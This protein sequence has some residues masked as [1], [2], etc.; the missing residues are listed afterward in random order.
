L[1]SELGSDCHRVALS[2]PGDAK[3]W[4]HRGFRGRPQVERAVQSW[5]WT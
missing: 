3:A 2:D 1:A 4:N 5:V